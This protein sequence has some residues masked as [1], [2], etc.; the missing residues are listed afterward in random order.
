MTSI[1]ATLLSDVLRAVHVEGSIAAQLA[2]TRGFVVSFDRLSVLY[3]A[4]I[5]LWFVDERLA[6][7]VMTCAATDVA[8]YVLNFHVWAAAVVC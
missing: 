8:A 7:D 2:I 4:S 5:L 3:N 1:T 6:T